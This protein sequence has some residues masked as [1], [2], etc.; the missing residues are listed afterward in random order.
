MDLNSDSDSENEET[1]HVSAELE[2]ATKAPQELKQLRTE[3][4]KTNAPRRQAEEIEEEAEKG[5]RELG[6][7]ALELELDACGERRTGQTNSAALRQAE[8]KLM[9]AKGLMLRLLADEALSRAGFDA[10]ESEG[11]PPA[12]VVSAIEAQASTGRSKEQLAAHLEVA[13]PAPLCRGKSSAAEATA[14][15]PRAASP[16]LAAPRLHVGMRVK[17]NWQEASRWYKGTINRALPDRTFSIRFDDGD[18]ESHVP[19]SRIRLLPPP[20]PPAVFLQTTEVVVD[21]VEVIRRHRSATSKTGAHAAEA[22]IGL[23]VS[24]MFEGTPAASKRKLMAALLISLDPPRCTGHGIFKGKVV[25]YSRRTG[26]LIEYED[27]DSEDVTHKT[28]V[29]AAA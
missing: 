28:L 15:V 17:S 25:D 1:P 27:G 23:V 13:E 12:S 11:M 7:L 3:I 2:A 22:F 26:Y 10:A 14:P 21:E 4:G 5:M 9:E 19:T 16:P 18:Y 20:A 8:A 6:H 24:K 29:R